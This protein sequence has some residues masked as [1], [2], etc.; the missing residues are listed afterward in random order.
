MTSRK[1]EKGDTSAEAEKAKKPAKSETT[2][3][4][5]PAP[6]DVAINTPPLTSDDK[7]AQQ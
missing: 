6:S 2:E 3:Q 4:V 7:E 5:D 1:P